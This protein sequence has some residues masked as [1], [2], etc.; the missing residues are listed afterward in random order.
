MNMKASR[1]EKP[2]KSPREPPTAV[3][4]SPV[5]NWKEEFALSQWEKISQVF[6]QAQ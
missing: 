1:N 2:R 6:Y 4:M 3:K 5:S